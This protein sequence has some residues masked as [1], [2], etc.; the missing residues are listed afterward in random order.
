MVCKR[1]GERGVDSCFLVFISH[2]PDRAVFAYLPIQAVK[3]D[4]LLALLFLIALSCRSGDEDSGKV[5]LSGEMAVGGV[6]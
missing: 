5:W 2:T 1:A 6:L 4:K 3:A